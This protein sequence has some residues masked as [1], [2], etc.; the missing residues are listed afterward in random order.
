MTIIL[1]HVEQNKEELKRGL[2]LKK[3]QIFLVIN[4]DNV[5]C[6]IVKDNAQV[7]TQH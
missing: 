5:N 1:F 2:A 6:K 3:N 7:T 4:V